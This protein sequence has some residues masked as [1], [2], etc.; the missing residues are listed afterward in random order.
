MRFSIFEKT[1]LIY[2]YQ[3][4]TMITFNTSKKNVFISS[5]VFLVLS[6][7]QKYLHQITHLLHGC[8]I[9]VTS[10]SFRRKCH[11]V[12]PQDT[13]KAGARTCVPALHHI[14]NCPHTRR[15]GACCAACHALISL[16]A[17]CPLPRKCLLAERLSAPLWHPSPAACR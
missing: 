12:S 8:Y 7:L 15:Y 11:S 6:P 13:Q 14:T 16:S 5:D 17:S 9:F 4:I 10:P 2:P 3:R 1:P